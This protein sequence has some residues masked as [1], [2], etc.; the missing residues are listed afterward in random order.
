MKIGVNILNSKFM[1]VLDILYPYQ[2]DAATATFY[3]PKG[4]VCLPT[5]L[6]KTFVQASVIANDI[7]MNPSQFRMYVVNAPRIMLSYQLLKEVY[8]FLVMHGIEARYA[9]VH[10]GGKTDEA[11]LEE[12]RIE[13]NVDG[14]N[15]PFSEIGSGTSIDG[16]VEMMK[17]SKEQDLPLILFSTYNSADKI[18]IARVRFTKQTISIIMNDEA[19][20]LVQEQFHDILH[21]LTSSRCYF[22]TATTIHTPSDKGRGM[23][24]KDIYGEIIYSMIPRE[25]I[26]IGKMVRPRLHIVKTDDV[27]SS[28]DYE[29]SLSKIIYEAFYQHEKVI[30]DKLSPKMLISVKGSGD[31]RKFLSSDEY[32]MLR[33]ERVSIYAVA[34]HEEIGNDVNGQKVRRQDFLKLLKAESAD[35]KQKM[36]IL[37][38]DVLSEGIDVP[39]ITGIMPLRTL[40]KSK[41]LQTFGRAARLDKEDRKRLELGEITPGDLDKM[42]KPYAYI[43]IPNVIQSNEDD[44]VNLTQ[45]ITELRDY[46]F[47]PS[48]HIVSSSRV[49][50]IPEIEELDGLNDIKV[51]IPNIGELIENLEAEIESEI[52]AKLS[53]KE[54]LLKNI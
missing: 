36:I 37:H 13:A 29:K 39:S 22:F 26:E 42:N 35:P 5:G 8:G 40:N 15:I 6:G 41:F 34:T 54:F 45:L 51:K 27:Y 19:H 25:A 50:G 44:K 11:E 1:N 24:N 33:S 43:I 48:E 46:G 23:N 20:Y 10:S 31:I 3:N 2:K 38:Y 17:K 16:I 52:N 18:E 12:M 28:Q 7:I 30:G 32:G 4:I 53:K 49:N 47:N 9:F 21:I 14:Y